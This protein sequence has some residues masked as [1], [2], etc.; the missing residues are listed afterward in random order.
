MTIPADPKSLSEHPEILAIAVEI[1]LYPAR[2][3]CYTETVLAMA[4]AA[5][6]LLHQRMNASE[7]RQQTTRIQE[8]D[9]QNNP[10]GGADDGQQED[11][12]D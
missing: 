6:R 3:N 8:G 4:D 1:T 5:A 11:H 12:I 7:Q 9:A 2:R 10:N